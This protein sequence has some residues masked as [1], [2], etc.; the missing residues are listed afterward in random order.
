MDTIAQINFQD[1]IIS[2]DMQNGNGVEDENMGIT[3]PFDP[4]KIKV[5]TKQMSLDTLIKRIKE[6]EIDLSPDFQRNEVWK[7]PTKSRLIESLLIRI[8]LP[9]FYMD[10]TNEDK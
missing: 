10:A 6:G 5:E 2:E 8:P 4:A 7:T 9:A 1:E 3:N